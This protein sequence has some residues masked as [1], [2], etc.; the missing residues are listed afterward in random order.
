MITTLAAIP[1][2][3]R[4]SFTIATDITQ[5]KP[6][7]NKYVT[8][9]DRV[10]DR[11]R[12]HVRSLTSAELLQLMDNYQYC[13]AGVERVSALAELVMSG[14][15]PKKD[16]AV[17]TGLCDR[18][19][20]ALVARLSFLEAELAEITPEEA[21][22]LSPIADGGPYRNFYCR[23]LEASRSGQSPE[24]SAALAALA[25]TGV[26][27]WQN[28]AVRLLGRLTVPGPVA[29]VGLGAV[30]P[31]LYLADRDARRDA[32]TAV[33]AALGN[34]LELRATA[35][36]MIVADGVARAELRGTTW[37]SDTLISDQLSS[38]ELQLLV[39]HARSA[40]PLVENY[41]H[42]KRE[43]LEVP[44]L[45]DFDRY[46]PV[47]APP[48]DISWSAAVE[49]VLQ[50]FDSVDRRFGDAARQLI[51]N[52]H[53]DAVPRA[54]KSTLSFTKD[55]P[56]ER[57]YISVNFNGT[58]RSVLL[59]AHELGHGVHMDSARHRPL[60]AASTP[61]VLAE[62]VALFFESVTLGV[63]LQHAATDEQRLALRA[64]WIE[65]QL[66]AI[67]RHAAL[68]TFE[69]GLRARIADGDQLD[70]LAI[71]EL[72]MSTQRQLHG[73]GV[74]LTPE[75]RNW[76]SYLE[77]LFVAPGT[78]Y[79]H[80]YGQFAAAALIELF[81]EHPVTTGQRL[82]ALVAA[83]GTAPP[84]ELLLLAGVDPMN[85]DTWQRAVH[86]LSQQIDDLRRT[87]LPVATH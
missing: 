40:Y 77:G 7:L 6:E 69:E 56:G 70:A 82:A 32:H 66:V 75:Y 63:L 16:A 55:V 23:V 46:A 71:G 10:A 83:G 87:S 36:A 44:V 37:L 2:W 78:S 14:G 57:P 34:E 80:L 18:A 59:L 86:G 12:G 19:W 1:T 85:P 31:N 30:L 42:V 5:A 28:L 51:L 64:R 4:T 41:Y 13:V 25:S 50:A 72:W 60:L 9:A 49:I 26:D 47:A 39:R 62:T 68:F 38:A 53:V 35:L 54:E 58:A 11:F 81:A 33:T 22:G 17:I 29:P 65:D 73:S 48:F 45:L 27:G 43:L 84:R 79:S 52:G 21:A 67:G 8:E 15:G 61:R 76:W 3:D 20:S 24:V 74:T